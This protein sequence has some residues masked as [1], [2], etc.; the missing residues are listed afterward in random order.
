MRDFEKP[1]NR[2][3][4]TAVIYLNSFKGTYYAFLICLFLSS[5]VLKRFLCLWKWNVK[6]LRQQKLLQKTLLLLFNLYFN[7][8]VPF[9]NLF[10]KGV[11]AKW[12]QKITVTLTTYGQQFEL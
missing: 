5:S 1:Q 10:F 9:K 6:S 7:R 12:Q 2:K 4:E 3:D 11:L 8:K